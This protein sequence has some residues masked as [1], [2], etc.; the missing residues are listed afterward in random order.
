MSSKPS[1]PGNPLIDAANKVAIA[2]AA[3]VLL[4]NGPIHEGVAAKLDNA[5][6]SFVTR[7]EN[8]FLILVTNGGDPDAAYV[9][10]RNLRRKYKSVILC[11]AGECFSAGTK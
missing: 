4:L 10:A 3:D 7:R 8:V 11:I 2:R 5:V 1:P 9:I 6:S